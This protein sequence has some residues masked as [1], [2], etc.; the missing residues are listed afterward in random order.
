[1]YAKLFII[2][3]VCVFAYLFRFRVYCTFRSDYK[4]SSDHYVIFDIE[5]SY[6]IDSLLKI[7]NI[8][9]ERIPLRPVPIE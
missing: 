2:V 6:V 4:F 1:M 3:S 5:K 7:T 8:S 9:R